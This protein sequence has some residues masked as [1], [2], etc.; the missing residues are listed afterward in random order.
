MTHIDV[1]VPEN[2][3]V[4]FLIRSG[5]IFDTEQTRPDKYELELYCNPEDE[6]QLIEQE[7]KQLQESTKLERPPKR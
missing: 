1:N 4:T 5:I 7:L 3:F 6:F 2:H